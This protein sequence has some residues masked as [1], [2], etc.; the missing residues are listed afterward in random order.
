MNSKRFLILLFE[1]IVGFFGVWLS[2]F[3]LSGDAAYVT[4]FGTLI[5][6]IITAKL[7]IH[8]AQE[9][10]FFSKFEVLNSLRNT[11][12]DSEMLDTLNKFQSISKP[13]LKKIKVNAWEDFSR[14]VN[15][16]SNGERSE[17]LTPSQYMDFIDEELSQAK[18]GD[19]VKAISLY[20]EG[21]FV[22]NSFEKNFHSA[23]KLAI[24]KG[25]VIERIFVCP[26][27]RMEDLKSTPYWDDH[28]GSE[29]CI[30]GRFAEQEDVI[31]SGLV[32]KNG[33]IMFNESVFIDRSDN[34]NNLAGIVSTHA[35][36]LYKASKDFKSLE[37]HAVSLS[38]FDNE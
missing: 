9:D 34:N 24:N 20:L 36:E 8:F 18:R 13:L 26:Q 4:G 22:D 10:S 2:F 15:S 3:G 38:I 6:I 29:G 11:N 19:K 37:K 21:E 28:L 5:Y 25:V 33:F 31:N 7:E 16:L 30:D 27:V 14:E 23:Q 32:I 17:S 1:V 35:S 12:I